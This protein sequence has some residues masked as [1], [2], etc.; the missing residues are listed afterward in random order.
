MEGRERIKYLKAC[1]CWPQPTMPSNLQAI[2]AVIVVAI[3]YAG[4]KSVLN[5]T[6]QHRTWDFFCFFPMLVC[7][8]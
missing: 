4:G 1:V 2:Q 3:R 7:F 5:Y 6:Q 8:A